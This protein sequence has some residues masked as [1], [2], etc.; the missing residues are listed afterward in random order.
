MQHLLSTCH[1]ICID[2]DIQW[3]GNQIGNESHGWRHHIMCQ[4]GSVN[5]K[6]HTVS[7][8]VRWPATRLKT[9][10]LFLWQKKSIV[11][12]GNAPCKYRI[13]AQPYCKIKTLTNCM[14]F[15][16]TEMHNVQRWIHKKN[17]GGRQKVCFPLRSQS[18][19]F[20]LHFFQNKRRKME[21]AL[22]SL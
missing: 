5:V 13:S 1:L 4:R 19:S 12:L 15:T 10:S 3:V 17:T 6:Q 22:I 8:I 18:L 16:P 11:L 21:T 7:L 20:S 14:H 9:S 2:S